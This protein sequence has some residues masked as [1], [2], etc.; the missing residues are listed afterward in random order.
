[1]NE[2]KS[3]KQ[4]II[5]KLRKILMVLEAESVKVDAQIAQLTL[6]N[7][8]TRQRKEKIDE[9]VLT[10]IHIDE[11][12]TEDPLRQYNLQNVKHGMWRDAGGLHVKIPKI[13]M[14]PN[15]KSLNIGISCSGAPL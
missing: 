8:P 4:E 5:T 6:R 13:N 1:M 15:F 9:E 11:K 10:G 3:R 12:I 7:H 2:T 14:M